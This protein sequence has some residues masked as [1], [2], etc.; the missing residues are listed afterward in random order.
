MKTKL[1]AGMMML[2]ATAGGIVGIASANTQP[3]SFAE[4][5]DNSFSNH[6][7]DAST[8]AWDGFWL[9]AWNTADIWLWWAGSNQWSNLVN[10]IKSAINWTL[11]MLWLIALILLLWGGFQM[12]T[13]AGDE[14]KYEAWFTILKQAWIWL[15]FIALSWFMVSIIFWLI[16]HVWSNTQA[17]GGAA[18]GNG[19]GN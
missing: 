10:I 11:W 14:K 19:G 6:A 16:G 7:Q 18:A 1:L 12:L 4:D 3:G 13:A 8:V 2:L 17:G 9:N 5:S 15:A